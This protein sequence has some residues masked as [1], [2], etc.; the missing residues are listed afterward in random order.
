MAARRRR[1]KHKTTPPPLSAREIRFC[2]FK[3]EGR[4]GYAAYLAAGFPE[5]PT[6]GAIDTA[7][8]RLVRKREI[9]EYIRELQRTAAD[10]AQVNANAVVQGL[11]RIAFAD[12]R[13]LYG[14]DGTL[15]PPHKWPDEIAAAVAGVKTEEKK[16]RGKRGAVAFTQD[17]KTEKRTEAFR[18]LAQILRMIGPEKE[19]AGAKDRPLVVGGEA[20]PG[21]L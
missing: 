17:V 1:R 4:T 7:I 16:A 18:L 14:K 6:R 12:R 19:D 11:S 2:Q 13:K 3:A 20:D 8:W 10:A 21:S 9:R 15:L 5:K